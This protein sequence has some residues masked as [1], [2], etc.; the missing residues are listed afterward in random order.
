V[1]IVI[2]VIGENLEA[3]C[4][5]FMEIPRGDLSS[6]VGAQCDTN[7]TA[8]VGEDLANGSGICLDSV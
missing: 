4:K 6:S 3:K 1:E 7:V 5:M 2:F 8:M